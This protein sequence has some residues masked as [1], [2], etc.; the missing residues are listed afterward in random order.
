VLQTKVDAQRDKLATELSWQR[1]RLSTFSGYSDRVIR[2]NSP[3]FNLPH[4]HLVPPL[5]VTRRLSFAEI[6]G[7]IKL[8]S[9]RYRVAWFAW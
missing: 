1:L 5:G 3:N 8:E 4:L 2:R 9:L 7:V 6:I